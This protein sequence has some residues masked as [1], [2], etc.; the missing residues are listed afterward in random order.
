MA[1]ADVPFTM[2]S[3]AALP[4]A[5]VSMK[6]ICGDMHFSLSPSH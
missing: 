1:E 2:W 3:L 6:T 4:Q 5:G